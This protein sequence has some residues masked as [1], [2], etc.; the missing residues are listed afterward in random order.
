MPIRSRSHELEDESF[1]QFCDALPA[2]WVPRKK[3]RDYGID[4]EVEIFD[5]NG[6]STGL[7]FLVQL[8]ATDKPEL[9]ALVRIETDELAYYHQLELPVVVVRYGSTPKSIY[10]QWSTTIGSRTNLRPDQGRFTYR[11]REEE[12]WHEDTPAA[13]RRTLEVRR[14]LA[15]YSPGAPIRIRLDLKQA[16]SD[17]RYP[18]ERA[19]NSAIAESQGTLVRGHGQAQLVE[20]ELTFMPGFLAL[21]I[22][23]LTS[24]T[25]DL[26]DADT[27]MVVTSA[28]YGL[29][30][31]LLHNKL[32]RQAEAVAHLLVRTSRAC[33]NDDLAMRACEAIAA[34]LPALARLAIINGFHAQTSIYHG[35]VALKIARAPQSGAARKIALDTFFNAA[36]ELA[37]STGGATEAAAHYSIGN[38]SRE[39][40]TPAAALYHY[41]RARRL[42]PAYMRTDYFLR[43]LGG[44]LLNAGHFVG[45]AR[46]YGAASELSSDP[47]IA[48]LLGDALLHSGQISSALEAYER[49]AEQ[50]SDGRML[51]EVTLKVLACRTLAEE[52]GEI[53]PVQRHAGYLALDAKGRD[54]GNRLREVLAQI[55]GLN[56]LARF[57]LGGRLSRAGHHEDA[58]VNF[59]LCAFIQPGDVGAWANA[60]ICGLSLGAEALVLS[61]LGVAMHHA[62][63]EAYERLRSDLVSQNASATAISA[64]DFVAA[65]L[66]AEASQFGEEEF[67]LRMLEGDSYTTMT[68]SGHGR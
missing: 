28:L 18:L 12:R 53:V 33:P 24:A 63:P 44:V 55:D 54:S 16:P 51:Q 56:P 66:L 8:R 5:A 43:E 49:S 38:F 14:A 45:A 64:L 3:E 59:L 36:L 21:R 27:E 57:N 4:C 26:P 46:A 39:Y 58:L 41:N 17:Q 1:R 60:A 6:S 65:E 20:V 23:T 2:K 22:D 7:T 48:F 68:L 37:R 40:S 52:L 10:W 31:L 30:R 61:I 29:V 11:Y 50:L 32:P 42:R 19:L 62:G 34:D 9:A 15:A 35:L 13:I 47:V 25:F 67:A